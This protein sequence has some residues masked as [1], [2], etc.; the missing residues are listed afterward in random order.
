M[1][2]GIHTFAIGDVHGRADLLD[3]MLVKI[4]NDAK[5]QSAEYRVVFLGDI[6]D[7]GPDSKSAVEL[8][9]ETVDKVPGSILILGNHDWFPIRMLDELKGSQ[10][11]EALRHWTVKM[12][13]EATLKSYG[14][15]ASTF[16]IED[17][18]TKFPREHLDLFRAANN[19][20]ELEGHILVHAGLEPGVSLADQKPYELMWIRDRFLLSDYDFG[21]TVVHGHT[22]TDTNL[23]E[24][25]GNRIAID[26]KAYETGMLTAAH[27][28]PDGY[29][30][31][32]G[33]MPNGAV[34]RVSPLGTPESRASRG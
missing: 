31:F 13:G 33:T 14:F 7:R 16:T 3:R 9:I 26:T 1:V 19:S 27:I 22:P 24:V 23:P 21:K 20:V 17:L 32:L 4:S 18:E 34:E 30:E 11:K 2:D 8:V 10:A 6:I 5:A 12:G 25:F 15:D 29:V 28:F